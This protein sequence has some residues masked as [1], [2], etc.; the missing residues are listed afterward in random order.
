MKRR[1]AGGNFLEFLKYSFLILSAFIFLF[2]L[3]WMLRTSV[4]DLGDIFA[5]P[6]IYFPKEIQLQHYRAAFD[7]FPLS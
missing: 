7:V 2:P 5:L 3:Y 1:K 4:M 6:V